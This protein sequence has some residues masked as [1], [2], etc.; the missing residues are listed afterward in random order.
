MIIIMTH[1]GYVMAQVVGHQPFATKTQS[2]FQASSCK[3]CGERRGTGK[4]FYPN[5]SVFTCEYHSSNVP[6]IQSGYHQCYT[7]ISMD[8]TVK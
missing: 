1:H 3:I 7:I 8:S 6:H 2:R 5:T 4:G